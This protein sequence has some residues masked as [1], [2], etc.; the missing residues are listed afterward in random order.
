MSNS[1][2]DNEACQG[3]HDAPCG[4]EDCY[5]SVN[6]DDESPPPEAP[7][8]FLVKPGLGLEVV[9]LDLL[10]AGP[11]VFDIE[12]TEPAIARHV[13]F[14]IK[15]EKAVLVGQR[16]TGKLMPRVVFEINPNSPKRKLRICL[17]QFGDTIPPDVSEAA[18]Y[19]GCFIHPQTT[20]PI[21]VYEIPF[22]LVERT[23]LD[24]AI[25]DAAGFAAE[26]EPTA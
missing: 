14:A 1:E 24:E 11:P 26:A 4:A 3:A 20:M 17:V 16:P 7:P 5:Q 2:A 19:L 8:S 12:V 10:N 23:G 25:V 18:T 15:Q 13:Y 21:A 22:S 9:E 6:T